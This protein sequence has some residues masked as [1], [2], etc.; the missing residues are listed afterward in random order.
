MRWFLPTSGTSKHFGAE[1]MLTQSTLVAYQRDGARAGPSNHHSSFLDWDPTG[2]CIFFDAGQTLPPVQ[3]SRGWA[4][5]TD[6]AT[7][8][9]SQQCGLG[10]QHCHA[11]PGV[12]GIPQDTENQL[13]SFQVPSTDLTEWWKDRA[14]SE[15]DLDRKFARV[16]CKTCSFFF[17]V[18]ALEVF[19][20]LY[21]F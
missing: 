1:L 18:I 3:C 19:L 5:Q 4:P 17:L 9:H 14:M 6:H 13:C 10:S 21:K 2:K 12:R 16:K 8:G 20:S 7:L 11:Y 15:G